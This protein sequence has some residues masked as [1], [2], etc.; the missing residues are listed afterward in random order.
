LREYRAEESSANA[1][2]RRH[3]QSNSTSMLCFFAF[4]EL[5][6]VG[7]PWADAKGEGSNPDDLEQQC[8]NAA[9]EYYNR[10]LLSPVQVRYP[11]INIQCFSTDNCCNGV[12]CS[13]C[14]QFSCK[15]VVSEAP[16]GIM[17]P[18]C[19]PG[20][21]WRD[22]DAVGGNTQC[23]TGCGFYS[24]S[25]ATPVIVEMDTA[26]K[27]VF[28]KETSVGE[29]CG[30]AEAVEDS[31]LNATI[32]GSCCLD[33]PFSSEKTWGTEVSLLLCSA[34]HSPAPTSILLLLVWYNLRNSSLSA[35]YR[36]HSL[37]AKIHVQNSRRI[38]LESTK[39]HVPFTAGSG[40]RVFR[41]VRS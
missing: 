10:I 40:V 8:K 32:P 11:D 12:A 20:G 16:Q 25:S 36:L 24:I 29:I 41:I 33:T 30:I 26:S 39:T 4:T 18:T 5:A 31:A 13:E 9:A 15:L 14:R 21:A 2:K 28:G 23:K 17:L 19:G 34:A 1:V 6:S 3:A 35:F 37:H 38:S 22:D 27:L 7:Y